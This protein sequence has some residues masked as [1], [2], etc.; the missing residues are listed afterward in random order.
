MLII[1][2]APELW[3]ESL[4]QVRSTSTEGAK[5]ESK[6][7]RASLGEGDW[8]G[9]RAAATVSPLHASP[10]TLVATR[11]VVKQTN[12]VCHNKL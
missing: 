2:V 4:Q 11:K 3:K 6:G 1:I 8:G 12:M 7:L 9:T 5:T 10:L